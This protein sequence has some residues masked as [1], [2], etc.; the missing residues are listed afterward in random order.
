MFTPSI[1]GLSVPGAPMGSVLHGV[2][3]PVI[4]QQPEQSRPPEADFDRSI[5]YLADYSGCGH[6]RMI[7]P[8][9]TLNA[10]QKAVI[11]S[12]TMMVIDE[13]YYDNTCTVRVQRQATDH[14]LK[15]MQLLRE[16][17]NRKGFKIVYEIDDIVFHEDIPEYNKFK[18]AFTDPVIRQCALDIMSMSDEIT[19]TNKFMQ[20]YYREKTGNQNITVIPNYP[21]KWWIGNHYDE[22]AVLRNYKKTRKRPRVVY[23]ASGAHFDVENRVNQRDDFYHLNDVI[24]K[25]AHEIQWVFLG[26]FPLTLGPLVQQGTIEFHDWRRLYEYPQLLREINPTLFIAPLQDNTFNRAKSDLK[27]IEACCMGVPIVCQDMCTYENAPYKFT[28]G[29]ELIDQIRRIVKSYSKYRKISQEARAVA[30][31]RWL[32]HDHNIDKYMELYKHPYKSPERKLINSLA[33]NQ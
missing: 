18:P 24:A 14:Q 1:P 26:A 9:H 16:F 31:D 2:P 4:P 5:N 28:T 21:P 8:E 30:E 20:E 12:T 10:H 32:E 22:Q 25:T 27:Y 29:D 7:W 6:W 17:A 15:F 33:E 3:A 19:V 13:R 23:A 11:H